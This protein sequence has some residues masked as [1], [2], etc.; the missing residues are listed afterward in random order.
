MVKD[1]RTR[2]I[3][4]K[5]GKCTQLTALEEAKW[6]LYQTQTFLP[7]L[8]V[9]FKTDVLQNTSTYGIRLADPIQSVV[10]ETTIQTA[11]GK[12]IEI[13]RKT[14]S[15][16]NPFRWMRGD[17][18][19]LG[20]PTSTEV[21]AEITEKIQ[22]PHTAAYVGALAS[23]VLSESDCPNFPKVY[24]VY[25]GMAKLFSFD[26]SGDYEDLTDRPWFL[27][28]IGKAFNLRMRSSVGS[29]QFQHTRETRPKL[30]T[31]D[32]IVLDGVTDLADDRH[33]TPSATSIVEDVEPEPE[34]ESDDDLSTASTD[35]VFAIESCDCS[36]DGS[37]CEDD[38]DEDE[39]FAWADIPN[40]PVVSTVMEKCPGTLYK[41]LK[42][43]DSAYHLA[44]FAQVVLAL[45]YAQR[46]FGLTHNDL[47]GNNIMYIPTALEF[48]TYSLEGVL[49]RIPT[50]GYLMKIID[51]DRA[52]FQIRLQKMREPKTFMSDQFRE[53]E[54]AGGQYNMEPFY[55]QKQPEYKANPSFDLVRLATS[56]FWDMFP[57][58][59][60]TSDH[61][62]HAVLIRWMTLPDQTSILF[63]KENPKHDRYHGFDQYKAIA[64]YCKD[65]AVPRKETFL[66]AFKIEKL[67]LG[68][69]VVVIES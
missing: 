13:H 34:G 50:H 3:S 54:E 29:P 35:D 63:G 68:E 21:S 28:N 52:I 30:V 32:D 53:D 33:S 58:G 48:V 6:G 66:S 9:L 43:T 23:V 2:P 12:T 8:E 59:P 49:Y 7:S 37:F 4:L 25:C 17:Y 45:A 55:T 15:I 38:G 31:G 18:G 27:Q 46:T 41:L 69:I 61:P 19:S 20:L 26:V 47:H 64:R 22:S 60:G 51:F 10:S 57:E 65:T 39:P 1:L 62:L 16:L 24:G 40:I 36:S 67:S 42:N 14:T 11:S 56:M 44:F 5:V